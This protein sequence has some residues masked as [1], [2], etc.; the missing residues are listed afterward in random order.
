MKRKHLT[1]F[2]CVFEN[3]WSGIN[4]DYECIE[5]FMGTDDF[6]NIKNAY[7]LD[8][9]AIASY[10]KAFVSYIEVPNKKWNKY[11]EPYKILL[12][13]FLREIL[14]FILLIM[15]Y[16]NLILRKCLFQLR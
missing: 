14:K 12:R 16:L 15:F 6:Q 5:S 1:E 8:S 10:F 7:G 9:Q 11:H 3:V 2:P 13:V 4:Y